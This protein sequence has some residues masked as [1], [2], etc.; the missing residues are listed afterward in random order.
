MQLAKLTTSMKLNW[1]CVKNLRRIAVSCL[2]SLTL[3]LVGLFH[4]N[5]S[6]IGTISEESVKRIVHSY[7]TIWKAYK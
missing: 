6:T 1:L 2:I 3:F 7:C 5:I 4:F